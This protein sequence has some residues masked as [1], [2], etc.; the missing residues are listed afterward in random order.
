MLFSRSSIYN[1]ISNLVEKILEQNARV[2]AKLFT[3]FK[4]ALAENAEK[5]RS[6]IYFEHAH[7]LQPRTK[8]VV[9]VFERFIVDS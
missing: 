4:L 5:Y 3:V 8:H 1:T 7:I 2:K 6:H 9:S